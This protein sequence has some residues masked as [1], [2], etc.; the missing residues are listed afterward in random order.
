M[1]FKEIFGAS[2]SLNIES[3]KDDLDTINLLVGDLISS[4]PQ[5]K[6]TNKVKF[7]ISQFPL[8]RKQIFLKLKP[9]FGECINWKSPKT[10]FNITPPLPI[11]TISGTAIANSLNQTLVSDMAS[12]GFAKLELDMAKYFSK[13]VGWDSKKSSGIFT[14]GGTGTNLYGAKIGLNK[15]NKNFCKTG[16][17]NAVLFD[18]DQAHSSHKTVADWLGIGIENNVIVPSDEY[19]VMINS[20]FKELLL[21]SIENGKLIGC[22][23]LS[24]GTTYD[25]AID[26]IADIKK[27]VDSVSQVKS[28]EYVPHIH[29][30]SVIGWIL[31]FFNK[32]EI[33][34]LK[35]DLSKDVFNRIVKGA[36]QISE[37]KYVDSFGVDFHKTGFASYSSSLFMLK[38]RKDFDCIS[39]GAE[40]ATHQSFELGDYSPGKFTL[41][42]SRGVNGPVAAFISLNA[43]GEEGFRKII[44]NMFNL[45]DF[46]RTKLEESEQFFVLNKKS[47][48]WATMFAIKSSSN[49]DLKVNLD[50]NV[51]DVLNYNK[52]Q[53]NFFN[54]LNSSNNKLDYWKISLSSK[55]KISKQGIPIA[56]LKIYPMSPLT[57]IEDNQKLFNWLEKMAKKFGC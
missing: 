55:Y 25:W 15:A 12:G 1:D 3:I 51:Q 43:I 7:E 19:G 32:F 9:Y 54:F 46:I 52:I 29:V 44:I 26:N 57:V 35:K 8:S 21:E 11:A 22:I 42:T 50:S 34:D 48:G 4:N 53:K 47:I 28:L 10:Q 39:K 6:K 5:F 23:N 31:L 36:S 24:G 56:A 38:E 16:V 2:D 33:N 30:D 17:N 37:L 27:I 49:F 18:S 40:G 20:N 45:S 14:F 13:L 41:E